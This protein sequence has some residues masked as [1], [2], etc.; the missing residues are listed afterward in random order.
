MAREWRAPNDLQRLS[1]ESRLR[2]PALTGAIKGQRSAPAQPVFDF[3]NCYELQPTTPNPPQLRSDVLIEEVPTA[4]KRL[5]SLSRRKRQAQLAGNV[6]WLTHRLFL[7]SGGNTKCAR[8]NTRSC[9]RLRQVPLVP[10]GQGIVHPTRWKQGGRGLTSCVRIRAPSFPR[11]SAGL[12]NG[13]QAGSTV[14]SHTRRSTPPRPP[15]GRSD[16][17]STMICDE[18]K[19]SEN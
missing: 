1:F 4:A 10:A 17:P 3:C 18:S 7:S 11:S 15:S 13:A 5:R 9:V 2:E 12:G 16:T 6:I 14:W 19:A 8:A